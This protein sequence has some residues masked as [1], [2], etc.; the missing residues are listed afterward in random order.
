M[1]RKSQVFR[2]LENLSFAAAAS[3]GPQ[4]KATRVWPTNTSGLKEKEN[5]ERMTLIVAS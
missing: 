2:P 4:L 3:Q 1:E 5:A